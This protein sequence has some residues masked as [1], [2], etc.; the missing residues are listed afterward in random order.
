MNTQ[1]YLDW[2]DHQRQPMID[3]VQLWGNVNSGS[4]NLPGLAKM[5]GLICDAFTPLGG[6]TE[7][8]RLPA[9]SIINDRGESESFET[10]RAF[11]LVIRPEATRRILLSGHMDT[12]YPESSSFQSCRFINNEM[13]NGP[14]VTDMKGG[15]VV[16]LYALLAFEQSSVAKNIGW[17]V[18]INP[19]EETGSHASASLLA[20]RA[21]AADIGMIFEP[22]MP[23]GTLAGQRK[24]SGNFTLV[25]RGKAAHAGREHHL[26]RNA[27]AA[28]AGAISQIDS[29]NGQHPDVTINVG[30]ISGGGPTNIV[31]DLAMCRFNIRVPNQSAIDW[32]TEQL[33]K[34]VAELNDHDGISSTLHGQFDRK[35][36]PFNEQQAS[37]FQL[38]KSCGDDIDLTVKHVPTGGCCDG[39]NLAAAGLPNID[40]LGVQGGNIHSEEEYLVL[41][42]LTERAKLSALFLMKLASGELDWPDKTPGGTE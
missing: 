16:M 26:G 9:V 13:M 31:P 23:D 34:V 14:G 19:D 18:L 25:V 37:L 4:R 22:T 36:K 28:L 17:E 41:S 21:A 6:E 32:C 30:K 42:S 24:G 38:L 15:L 27:I 2:L 11:S 5:H 8:I 39:N 35:P 1:S 20:E 12:V 29:L 3:L 10:G 33:D 7:S 40:T